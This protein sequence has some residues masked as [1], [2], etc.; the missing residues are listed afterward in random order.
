MDMR[1]RILV[2]TAS[3]RLNDF[4]KFV[5]EWYDVPLVGRG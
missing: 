5:E 3:G 4:Q 1:W 2:L